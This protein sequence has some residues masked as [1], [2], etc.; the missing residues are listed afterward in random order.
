[1]ISLKAIFIILAL[2]DQFQDTSDAEEKT[3]KI[4]GYP[5]LVSSTSDSL[6]LKW[7]PSRLSVDD[8]PI[9]YELAYFQ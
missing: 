8:Q 4:S 6:K 2:G 7:S 1:M 3:P 9:Q 5:K